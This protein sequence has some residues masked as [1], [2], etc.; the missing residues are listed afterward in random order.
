MGRDFVN[1]KI[2]FSPEMVKIILLNRRL[3]DMFSLPEPDA[4]AIVIDKDRTLTSGIKRLQEVVKPE[5]LPV[6]IASPYK[7]GAYDP[8]AIYKKNLLSLPK[9]INEIF[10]TDLFDFNYFKYL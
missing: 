9:R 4:G 3:A 6:V 7:G 1:T 2:C 10:G 8:E 5:T